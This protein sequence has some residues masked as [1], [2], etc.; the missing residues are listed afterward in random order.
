MTRNNKKSNDKKSNDKTSNDKTSNNKI[1]PFTLQQNSIMNTV[2]DA[3]IYSSVF[4]GTQRIMD[5]IFGNRKVDINT[6]DYCNKIKEKYKNE[7]YN[8]Y[9]QQEYDKCFKYK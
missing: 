9:L 3:F 6:D 8:E 5:N 2:K 4:S 1:Q 7:E